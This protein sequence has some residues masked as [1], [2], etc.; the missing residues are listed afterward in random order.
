MMTGLRLCL[1][2][3]AESQIQLNLPLQ[4]SYL[5]RTTSTVGWLWSQET[6]GRTW[7]V[8]V[9]ASVGARSSTGPVANSGA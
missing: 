3:L 6:C 1:D 4:L 2:F 9:A 7:V 8:D 5:T